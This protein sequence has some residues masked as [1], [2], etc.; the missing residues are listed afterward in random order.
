MNDPLALE[1]RKECQQIMGEC[2]ADAGGLVKTHDDEDN[3]MAVVKVAV[4]M[5]NVRSRPLIYFKRDHEKE[6]L[7]RKAK[8]NGW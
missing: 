8:G 1:H 3:P 6:Q 4:A 7:E 5:F 2:I